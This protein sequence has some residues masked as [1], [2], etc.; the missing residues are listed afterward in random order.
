MPGVQTF[1]TMEEVDNE[2]GA[3][4]QELR[5]RAQKQLSEI[6]SKNDVHVRDLLPEADLDQDD[7]NNV[8][9]WNGTDREWVQSGLTGDQLE[10]VYEIDATGNAEKKIIGIFAFSN[11]SANPL[12]SQVVFEDGTGS[13]FERAQVQE[14]FHRDEQTI[15]LLEEPIII[16]ATEDAVIFQWPTGDG[17]DNVV[18][19]GAVAEKMGNT[20]GERQP[21]QGAAVP[22]RSPR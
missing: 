8:N 19:H 6:G 9:G 21:T 13:R 3:L 10:Q 15:A 1:P 11:I 2:E 22:G 7:A 17:T 20:L 5:N 18:Y 14:V 4:K 12:T 16:N